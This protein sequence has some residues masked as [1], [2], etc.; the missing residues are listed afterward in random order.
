VLDPKA[1]IRIGRQ[2]KNQ[3]TAIQRRRDCFL[4]EQIALNKPES[5]IRAS[6]AEKSEPARG[7]II[8]SHY[9]VP[10]REQSICQ[11]ATDE[12]GT[13]GYKTPQTKSRPITIISAN[14]HS[15]IVARLYW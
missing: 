10:Q 15:S 9:I 13:T 1:H 6:I 5:L 7:E 11:T 8:V 14:A 4:V 12:P 3:F 2:M